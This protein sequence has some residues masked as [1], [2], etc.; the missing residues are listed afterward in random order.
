MSVMLTFLINT[1]VNLLVGLIVALFLGPSEYGKF[2]LSIGVMTFG[3]A[4]AFEWIRQCGVRFYSERSRREASHVRATL[5]AAFVASVL[6]FLPLGAAAAFFG[7]EF[8]LPRDLAALAFAA[9]VANGL[10]DYHTALVRARF[11]DRLF[12]KVIGTKNLLAIAMIAG[13]AW[14]T[15][16]ARVALLGGMA[17]LLG[18]LL[19]WRKRLFDPDT[20]LAQ[21]DRVL[22]RQYAGYAAPIVA[23]IVL[24]QL[25]PLA[26]RDFA[27]RFYGFAETGRFALAYDLGLRALQAI[28][29]ALDVL[30]FQFAV[31]AHDLHGA[32][33]AKAQIASNMAVVFAIL[34]PACVGLWIVLPSVE[35]LVVPEAY[36]G[37]FAAFLTLL[38]PGLF[39]FS[40][41]QFALNAV[42]QIGQKTMPMVFSALAACVADLIFVMV[43]PR[44]DDASSLAI[45]Q[46]LAMGVGFVTLAGFAQA[47]RPQWPRFRDI[48]L[49]SL[50][51]LGMAAL[52]GPLREKAP[53]VGLMLAQVT[54]GG[55]FYALIV[56][57][58]DIAGLRTTLV[59]KAGPI[60]LR[61]I[62]KIDAQAS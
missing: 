62:E 29:S 25:I 49:T 51:S 56:A 41:G 18:A 32:D 24:Y 20:S 16:S 42:F 12:L 37:P 38:L 48:A 57:V 7:P 27:A 44:G 22:A 30:L 15:G 40:L 33:Q 10:F 45:A 13:G 61:L 19:I 6:L 34:L 17:S 9:S 5:D 59:A 21:A 52:A 50:A 53:G 35:A 8:T 58:F 47:T 26:N 36:R 31:R 3:Q 46:S 39:L 55:G 60:W 28:G 11:E 14:A 54:I 23:A 2:A 1:L 4:L 43:L